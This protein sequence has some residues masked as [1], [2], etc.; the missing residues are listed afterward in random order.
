MTQGRTHANDDITT[1]Q[2][3]SLKGRQ[4]YGWLG[5]GR[6]QFFVVPKRKI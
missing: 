4:G 1:F 6:E 2:D 5:W 3:E